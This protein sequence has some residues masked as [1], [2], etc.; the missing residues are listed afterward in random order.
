MR[1]KQ[2]CRILRQIRAEIAR[3]NDIDLVIRECTFQGE[4]RGTCPRCEQEVR[5]LE[6][7]LEKRRRLQKGVALA[8]VAAGMIAALSGCDAMEPP[9][10]VAR[11]TP[12]VTE[13]AVIFLGEV[14]SD[15][16][17]ISGDI[18]EA[19]LPPEDGFSMDTGLSANGAEP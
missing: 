8:G 16:P 10:D 4:C 12:R 7:Q 2:T 18:A 3:R 13:D 15:E 9:P 11:S 17:A 19:T 14:P 5:Y 6:E 1:R